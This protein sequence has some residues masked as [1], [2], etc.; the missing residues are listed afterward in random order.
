MLKSEKKSNHTSAFDEFSQIIRLYLKLRSFIHIFWTWF[1][2]GGEIL[3]FMTPF[4]DCNSIPGGLIWAANIKRKKKV[5][6]DYLRKHTK[7][8]ININKTTVSACSILFLIL[9]SQ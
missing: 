3:I 7:K 4:M 6:H 1:A 5:K 2:S 9:L 8:V